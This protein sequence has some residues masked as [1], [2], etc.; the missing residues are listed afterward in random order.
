MKK[1]MILLGFTILL[2]LLTGCNPTSTAPKTLSEEE[3]LAKYGLT[4]MS[5][6]EMMAYLEESV[7]DTDAFNASVHPTYL[8]LTDKASETVID[9]PIED[10]FYLSVAPY[11]EETHECYFHNLATCKGELAHVTVHVTFTETDGT[12]LVDEDL[13]TYQN[14]FF[15]IWLPLDDE[16]L[17]E[18]TYISEDGLTYFGSEEITTY[19]DPVEDPTCITTIQLIAPQPY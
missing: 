11:I 16:G 5:I 12:V 2:L 19:D 13:Q 3:L 9:L 7:D 17:L 15:A 18:I 8:E 6:K 10:G 1:R 14:G 4:G